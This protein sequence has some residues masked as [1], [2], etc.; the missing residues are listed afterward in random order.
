MSALDAESMKTLAFV[1]SLVDYGNITLV[2][3]PKNVTN[4]L[5]RVLNAA[6]R[7]VTGTRKYDRG[8]SHLLQTKL[9]WLDVPER[10]LYKLAL[11][12]H[13]CLQDK[14]PHYLSN[15]CVPVSEVASRQQLRSASRHQLLL[16]PRYRQRTFSRRAFAVAGAPAAGLTFWNSLADELQTYSSDRFIL[17][18]KTFLFATFFTSVFSVLEA[19][20]VM[21]Y[22]NWWLTLTLTD[23]RLTS[24]DT[25]QHCEKGYGGRS[26]LLWNIEA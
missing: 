12:V 4:K 24:P 6:A 20:A 1:T 5:Q 7:I 26:C 19:F 15:Y 11:M 18:L 14:A 16:I 17:A 8:L 21:R 9:H 25:S 13:R 2:G 10:V 3:A 23:L 22:I